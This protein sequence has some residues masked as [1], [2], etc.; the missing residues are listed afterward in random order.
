M[1]NVWRAWLRAIHRDV[2]YFAI[3]FTVNGEHFAQTTTPY[4]TL[5]QAATGL[6]D[7]AVEGS[8]M[9][10]VAPMA[11]ETSTRSLGNSAFRQSPSM[12]A[13][14]QC[15]DRQQRCLTKATARLAPGIS[16]I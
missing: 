10:H 12:I 8:R 4:N 2:G 6:T 7:S 16:L 11:V 5:T 13:Q 15:F 3:G 9:S 1:P 14:H